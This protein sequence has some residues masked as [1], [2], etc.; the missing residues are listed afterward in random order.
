VIDVDGAS[1]GMGIMHLLG[2]VDP[3]TVRIGLKVKAL[4]KPAEQRDGAITDILY[5]KPMG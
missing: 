4:W 5:W 3:Q 2:E 1:T